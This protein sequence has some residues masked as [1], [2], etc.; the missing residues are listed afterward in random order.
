MIQSAGEKAHEFGTAN[1]ITFSPEPT[2]P[3]ASGLA[4]RCPHCQEQFETAFDTPLVEIA[5][6]SCGKRFSLAGTGIELRDAAALASLGHFE[7]VERI[8]IGGFGTVWKGRDRKLDRI[9]AIKVPRRGSLD[10]TDME[11]F[12]R[13]AR[14][15]PN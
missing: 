4:I 12:L 5:C 9:V 15:L 2:P 1:T 7:L 6:E 8:G 10:P 11:K 13:E 3:V 14:R